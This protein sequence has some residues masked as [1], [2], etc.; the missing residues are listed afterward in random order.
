M[1][2]TDSESPKLR[3]VGILALN[4]LFLLAACAILFYRHKGY[5]FEDQDALYFVSIVKTAQ[6]WSQGLLTDVW[7][8]TSMLGSYLL[9][10]PATFPATWALG[11]PVSFTAAKIAFFTVLAAQLFLSAHFFCRT[12]GASF[13]LS[14]AAGWICVNL[15]LPLA[16]HPVPL[17]QVYTVWPVV[18][19]GASLILFTLACFRML[20]RAETLPGNIA[21]AA[22]F[23]GF[24][25]LQILT[26]MYTA[27]LTAP[28]TAFGGVALLL[29]ANRRELFWKL[30]AGVLALGLL[31]TGP[32]QWTLGRVGFASR[33]TFTAEMLSNMPLSYLVSCFFSNNLSPKLAV[34]LAL[35]GGVAMVFSRDRTQRVC[36]AFF[37]AFMVLLGAYGALYLAAVIDS[38]G[39]PRPIYYE[40]VSTPVYALFVSYA[41]LRVWRWLAASPLAA[42]LAALPGLGSLLARCAAA[43]GRALLVAGLAI[44]LSQAVSAFWLKKYRPAE[45]LT[46]SSIT[47]T[48]SLAGGLLPGGPF[49]GRTS[50]LF[51][52]GDAPEGMR[53]IPDV[54]GQNRYFVWQAGMRNSHAMH[55]LWLF[56][57]PTLDGYDQSQSVPYYL[58]YSRLASRSVWTY[59]ISGIDA[60]NL[61]LLRASGTRFII[62]RQPLNLPGL[63]ERMQISASAPAAG[64]DAPARFLLYELDAPNLGQYSPVEL[65]LAPTLNESLAA[66]ADPS[67][68]FARQ[69][70]LHEPLPEGPALTPGALLDLRVLPGALRIEAESRGRSLLL[71]P[72]EFSR[73][74]IWQP[75]GPEQAPVLLRRADIAFTAFVFSGRVSGSLRMAF[76]PWTN[77]SA[78]LRDIADLRAMGLADVPLRPL[79]RADRYV[80]PFHPAPLRYV[81]P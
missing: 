27:P 61:P 39:L 77:A 1:T 41:L 11:L 38:R 75:D 58:L 34:L 20:G 7:A 81:R 2:H 76:G 36:G 32:L 10:N 23:V 35:A 59:N 12:M 79:A 45:T 70:L 69:A 18:G 51:P 19:H 60:P 29:C 22:G 42:R 53:I 44:L 50:S 52:Y 48:V 54:R 62:T 31:A 46:P 8:P 65:R 47:E 25:L 24:T 4:L 56:G 80:D 64:N 30:G 68:D 15:V 3:R 67:F 21:A 66:L 57:I 9:F 26:S 78:R 40:Y 63:T 14:L 5:L 17:G 33:Q 37:L 6:A 43:P 13:G 28:L 71:L 55:N 72:F 49:L 74:M 73:S 16:Q